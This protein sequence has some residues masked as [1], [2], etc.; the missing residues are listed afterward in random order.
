M[1]T[2]FKTPESQLLDFHLERLDD[3][4]REQVERRLAED[5]GFAESSR[6]LGRLLKPLDYWQPG[7][8]ADR[9]A[10]K[11]LA[12]IH[13]EQGRRIV[14]MDPE[15][16]GEYRPRFI[17]LRNLVAA[18][19]CVLL[20]IGVFVP[21]ITTIRAQAQRTACASNLSTIFRGTALYREAFRRSLPYAGD[22]RP[23]AWLPGA[24]ANRPYKS[25]SRHGFLLVK[26][27][28]GPTP[29]DF[30]CPSDE[31]AEVMDVAD[32][33]AVD[34]F[35]RAANVSYD[36]LNLT[37]GEPT[38][39]P[40]RN[41]VYLGDPSPLFKDARFDASVDPDT[42]NSPAHG[43]GGQ[44]LMMLDGR[45]TWARTPVIGPDADNI[46]LAGGLRDYRGVESR[47]SDDDVHLIPGYPRTDPRY[48]N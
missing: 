20:L 24:A 35:T 11:V 22:L 32:F 40:Q 44:T 3:A 4:E 18:A 6:R 36:S 30:T 12:V 13:N 2:E 39:R 26:Y 48:A 21:G 9:I 1:T 10:D 28:F 33:T 8:H 31:N 46:W 15:L 5:P 42:A 14:R 23:S 25:N 27:G 43:R 29:R 41:L 38:L 16:G 34:D 37:G 7:S 19:A 47:A 17:P 45:A